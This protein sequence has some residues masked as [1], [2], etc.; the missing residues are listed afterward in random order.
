MTFFHDRHHLPSPLPAGVVAG[1]PF[2]GVPVPFLT[3]SQAHADA[4]CPE[5]ERED[6]HTNRTNGS[7]IQ[8]A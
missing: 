7:G 5:A 8:V 1:L 6:G 2:L 3:T 4:G